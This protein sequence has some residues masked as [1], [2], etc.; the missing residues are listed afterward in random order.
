MLDANHR[1]MYSTE[2]DLVTR[3]KMLKGRNQGK[4]K[5]RIWFLRSELAKV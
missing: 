3:S 1:E 2:R 5:Q 4:D